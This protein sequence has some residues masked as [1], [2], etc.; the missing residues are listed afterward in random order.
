MK[1]SKLFFLILGI[2][3]SFSAGAQ[4]PWSLEDCINYAHSNNLQIK[5]AVLQA[6]VAGINEK[7]AVT[8][9]LPDLNAGINR[10]YNFGRSV[11]PF[12]NN[13]I[14]NNSVS[15]NFQL[16]SSVSLFN[17]LQ[18]YNNIKRNQYSTL[19][20]ITSIEQTKIEITFLISAAYLD[21]LFKKELVNV[22][23]NQM[24]VTS[25][26]VNRTEKL[27]EAGNV[28]KGNLLEIKAQLANEKLTLTN[29]QNALNL[30]TLNLCQLLDLDSISG[31]D[32]FVPD[33]IDSGFLT[34]IPSFPVVYNEA[35]TYLP[36]IKGAQYELK[37][38]EY[39]LEMQKGARSPQLYLSGSIY[40]GYSDQ[41]T[42]TDNNATPFETEIGYLRSNPSQTVVSQMLPSTDYPYSQQLNDNLSERLTIGLQIP[43]L[44]R[45][46]TNNNI[47]K[48]RIQVED[49]KYKLDQVKQELMKDIQQAYSDAVSAK[50]KFNAAVEAVNSYKEAFVY[51]EQKF[52]V[53][54]VNSVEYNIA[55]NNFTKAE[56]DLLQA[57]YEYIFS[58]KILDFYRGIPI[59][60]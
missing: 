34:S 24:A 52:N 23:E 54:I 47:A 59:T 11:D 26:Q 56:S 8:N 22:A 60:L 44:N 7:Q 3:I 16:T 55:K 18:N 46:E 38:N 33:T 30:S 28:A 42:L 58:A 40:T 20:T 57:K 4:E 50:E 27:V 9:I 39:Y 51:T 48:A 53:G 41:R 2:A 25:Q 10:N 5:R 32:V 35:L 36:H 15:D 13:F 29:A 19:A 45:W 49:S 14:T 21:I 17:G 12:T 6:D 37:S 43:I 1:Y 31:F